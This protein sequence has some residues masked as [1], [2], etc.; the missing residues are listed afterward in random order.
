GGHVS[1]VRPGVLVLP[2]YPHD[3]CSDLLRPAEIV[4]RQ[5]CEPDWC[6]ADWYAWLGGSDYRLCCVLHLGLRDLG[7]VH[8]L[9]K[10]AGC[11]AVCRVS[12]CG[13][14]FSAGVCDEARRVIGVPLATDIG[15]SHHYTHRALAATRGVMGKGRN[16]HPAA[17]RVSYET[18]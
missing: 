9:G 13:G 8:G 2:F 16:R 14:G 17:E 3:G 12:Y 18:V 15:W 7:L 10:P 4:A 6:V 11:L 1:R 5:R